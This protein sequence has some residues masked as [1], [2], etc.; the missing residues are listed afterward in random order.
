[1]VFCDAYVGYA[2]VQTPSRGND[3][4]LAGKF[5]KKFSLCYLGSAL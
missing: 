2:C 4:A 5:I 1:M 3:H